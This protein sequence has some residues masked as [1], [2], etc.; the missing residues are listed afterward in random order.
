MYVSEKEERRYE[1][2][3][4]E[5]SVK[6]YLEYIGIKMLLLYSVKTDVLIKS[7]LLKFIKGEG[8]NFYLTDI[9]VYDKGKAHYL[10][11]DIRHMEQ[12]RVNTSPSRQMPR[13]SSSPERIQKAVM[14]KLDMIVESRVEKSREEKSVS[15]KMA[16]ENER[17]K[18]LIS[19]SRGRSKTGFRLEPIKVNKFQMR[20]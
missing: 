3:L 15:F 12:K 17:I 19:G 1:D 8:N 13:P 20:R 9:Q 18:E 5:K 14:G 7:S 11:G 2:E 16:K 6:L 4:R 10:W